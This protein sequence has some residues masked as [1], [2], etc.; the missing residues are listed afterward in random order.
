MSGQSSALP[1]THR[2]LILLVP[3]SNDQHEHGTDADLQETEKEALSI[4][5][6]VVGADCREK[7][8]Q[9]P[10]SHNRRSNPL[11]G[12]SLGQKHDR[13]RPDEETEVEDG[14]APRKALTHVKA[15]IL[16]KTKQGL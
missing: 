1:H 13:I 5:A 7:Q 14:G 15:Q 8:A 16:T 3:T 10:Q 11:D 9:T 2:L 12:I 4:D 6:L